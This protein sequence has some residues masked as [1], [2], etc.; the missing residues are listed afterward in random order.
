ME[1]TALLTKLKMDYLEAQL[2]TVCEPAAKRELDYPSFLTE[3][4]NV[5]WQGRAQRGQEAR[6]RQARF[7]WLKTLEQFDFD[8]QPSLDRKLVR[9]LATASFVAWGSNAIILGPPGVCGLIS[10]LNLG[11]F[12]VL[13]ESVN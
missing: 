7:P 13:L 12:W 10:P 3:A 9:E 8:F 4:L 6:L 2:E 1:L 11:P 5:E